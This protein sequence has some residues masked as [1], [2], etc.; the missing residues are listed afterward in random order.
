MQRKTPTR[1][2]PALSFHFYRATLLVLMIIFKSS[3]NDFS[4]ICN[5]WRYSCADSTSYTN[6]QVFLYLVED[7]IQAER[8]DALQSK[9]RLWGKLKIAF[10]D[11]KVADRWDLLYKGTQGQDEGKW[12]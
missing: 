10:Q 4:Q 9:E 12:F 11:L 6:V 5:T 8:A 1:R 2:L 3:S 7:Y